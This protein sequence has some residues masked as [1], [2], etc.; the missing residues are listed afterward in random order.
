MSNKKN[1]QIHNVR[2]LGEEAE[3]MKRYAAC[4]KKRGITLYKRIAM[5]AEKDLEVSKNLTRLDWF[6]QV[7]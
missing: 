5:L 7:K 4:C 2:S 3:V 1:T 6:N